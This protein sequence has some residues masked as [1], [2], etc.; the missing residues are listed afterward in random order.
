MSE[1]PAVKAKRI[2]AVSEPVYDR[3]TEIRSDLGNQRGRLVTYS[4]V[5]ETL[6]DVYA[7]VSE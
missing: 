5:L 6:L 1:A 3:L 7:E 4:E 2:V